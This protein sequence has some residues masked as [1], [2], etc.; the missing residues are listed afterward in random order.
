MRKKTMATAIAIF[1]IVLGLIAAY[2]IL[3]LCGAPLSYM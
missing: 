3:M 1:I 2:T